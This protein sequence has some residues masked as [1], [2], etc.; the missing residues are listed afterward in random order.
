MWGR[1]GGLE[2]EIINKYIN[3]INKYSRFIEKN[4]TFPNFME[5]L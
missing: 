4:Q 2:V 1:K 3:I 5:D